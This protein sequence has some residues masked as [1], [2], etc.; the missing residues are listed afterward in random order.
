MTPPDR[1][2]ARAFGAPKPSNDD[3][4]EKSIDGNSRDRRRIS[5]SRFCARRKPQGG[6]ETPWPLAIV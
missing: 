5:H 2:K 6:G 1:A 3:R 4:P